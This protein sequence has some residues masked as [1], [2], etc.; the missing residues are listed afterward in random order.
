MR[1][2]DNKDER[3]AI[4]DDLIEKLYQNLSGTP[5]KKGSMSANNGSKHLKNGAFYRK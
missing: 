3:R 2:I 4:N 1:I 5:P